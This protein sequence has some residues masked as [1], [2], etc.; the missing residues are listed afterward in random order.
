MLNNNQTDK[1]KYHNSS[2]QIITFPLIM[3]S[4]TLNELYKYKGSGINKKERELDT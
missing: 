4:K 1:T 3:L 2:V